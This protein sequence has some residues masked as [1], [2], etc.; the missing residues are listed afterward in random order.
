MAI[1]VMSQ[2]FP[3]VPPPHDFP[4]ERIRPQSAGTETQQDTVAHQRQPMAEM[5]RTATVQRLQ[6]VIDQEALGV[7]HH[8]QSPTAL[9]SHES[10]AKTLASVREKALDE[11]AGLQTRYRVMRSMEI[12]RG[13]VHV[14]S[15]RAWPIP[16]VTRN[17]VWRSNTRGGLPLDSVPRPR[18]SPQREDVPS[19]QLDSTAAIC[20]HSV[21]AFI[22]MPTKSPQ[23][24][25]VSARVPDSHGCDPFSCSRRNPRVLNSGACASKAFP[26]PRHLLANGCTARPWRRI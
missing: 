6:I 25:R 5:I 17:R 13:R 11:W 21:A 26:P 15:F 20:S 4:S 19:R 7:G 12:R 24:T 23:E 9:Q 2:Q 3:I 16:R 1:E 10:G 22:P 8:E 14:H 18:L